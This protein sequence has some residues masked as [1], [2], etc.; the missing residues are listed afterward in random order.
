M[1]DRPVILMVSSLTDVASYEPSVIV[2]LTFSWFGAR[3]RLLEY[4]PDI[5]MLS[6]FADVAENG[7]PVVVDLIGLGVHTV[8]VS[9]RFG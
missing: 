6:I 3:Y 7:Q 9:I 8:G 1:Y 5:Y 2:G 4:R